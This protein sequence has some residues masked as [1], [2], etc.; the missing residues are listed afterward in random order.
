MFTEEILA[1]QHK[2]R[3]IMQVVV[4]MPLQEMAEEINRA[5]VLGPVLDPTAWRDGAPA[6]REWAEL[7]KPL[8]EFQRLS[9]KIVPAPEVAAGGLA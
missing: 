1:T 9:R 8:I 7:L 4:D 5:D 6:M 2:I 3:L